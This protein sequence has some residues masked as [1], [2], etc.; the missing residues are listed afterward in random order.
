[1]TTRDEPLTTD[2]DGRLRGT[3]AVYVAD[4]AVFPRLPSKGLTFTMMANANRVGERVRR[5]LAGP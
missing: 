4:G 3:R 5:A 1:M 2:V